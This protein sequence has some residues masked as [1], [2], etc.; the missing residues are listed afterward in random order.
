M[1]RETRR[2]RIRDRTIKIAV[3]TETMRG[4]TPDMEIKIGITTGLTIE[5]GMTVRIAM[6]V[7]GI[8]GANLP[9]R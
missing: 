1:I 7:I 4:E 2:L 9:T 5:G 3:R 6:G 8:K